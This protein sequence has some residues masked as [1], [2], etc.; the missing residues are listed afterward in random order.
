MGRDCA[1]SEFVFGAGPAGD[2]MG[3]QVLLG[4]G[5]HRLA[6]L[7]SRPLALDPGQPGPFEQ[8]LAQVPL[9]PR[10]VQA[11]Q[12]SGAGEELTA[13]EPGAPFPRFDEAEALPV[14][15]AGGRSAN[16]DGGGVAGESLRLAVSEDARLGQGEGDVLV[17]PP[18][19]REGGHVAQGE[20]AV[21]PGGQGVRVDR[22]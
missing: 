21:V 9:S 14:E 15:G 2:K 1:T 8:F 12:R 18:R 6:D 3:L 20:D 16:Q 19:Q 13:A 5:G 7:F 17:V 10:R 11:D 22:Y 4:P